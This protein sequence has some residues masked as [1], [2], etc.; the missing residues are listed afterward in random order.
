MSFHCVKQSTVD[1]S[2][3]CHRGLAIRHYSVGTRPLDSS[4]DG[5]GSGIETGVPRPWYPQPSNRSN[6]SNNL[7][8]RAT[9]TT[10]LVGTRPLSLSL[11]VG[12]ESSSISPFD[13]CLIRAFHSLMSAST[14][15][16][17]R[18]VVKPAPLVLTCVASVGNLVSFKQTSAHKVESFC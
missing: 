18:L 17:N 16:D 1:I 13:E 10:K 11:H 3:T 12:G 8:W 15:L 2:G 4:V 7:S 14:P 9:S 5:S 6:S